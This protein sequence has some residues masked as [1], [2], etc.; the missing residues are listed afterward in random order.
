[1][2]PH[3]SP[4]TIREN[5]DRLRN[6]RDM[7]AELG[8]VLEELAEMEEETREAAVGHHR[9]ALRLMERMR[10]EAGEIGL[11]PHVR[12]DRRAK[13]LAEIIKSNGRGP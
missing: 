6:V 5:D 4:S 9:H 7:A 12:E 3:Y 1:M 8:L 10:E 11:P 2:T 13:R